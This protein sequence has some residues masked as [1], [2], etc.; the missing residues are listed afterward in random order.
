MQK[1][2]GRYRWTIAALLFFATTVN[3]VDRQVLSFVMTDDFFKKEM[4][5][6]PAGTVLTDDQ[7]AD[8]LKHMSVVDAVFK[9]TYA[10][11]FLIFGS[12]IDKIGTKKGYSSG[13]IMWSLAGIG[14][15]FVG[16]IS[17][18]RFTRG[19]LGL[20]ESANFPSAIKTVAEW[21]PKKERSFANG[22]FNAGSNLGVIATAL[23]VPFIIA[24]YGW[25][26]AF[27]VTGVLGFLILVAWLIFYDKPKESK[28]VSEEELAYICQDEAEAKPPV[29]RMPIWKVMR[30][31]QAWVFATGKFFGDPIWYFYLTWLPTFFNNN[32]V[33][34]QKLDLKNF[35]LS[36]F[37]I[38]AISDLGSVFFGWLSTRFMMRG[39]SEN[40]A[41]K[42]TLLIC[43]LCVVPI[44]FASTTNSL[45]VAIGLIS[46]ATAA[47]QGWSANVYAV[48]SNLFPSHMVASVT[49]FGGT[50]GSIG[51]VILGAST[52]YIVA[53]LG[54]S[55]MFVIASI[56]YLVGLGI[57]QLLMPTLKPI[58]A[59]P[60]D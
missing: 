14:N 8:F 31:R 54:Y 11:G 28:R 19:L 43:A 34:D 48:A 29:K 40:R 24:H 36:F 4:L 58:E 15:A 6:I 2:R 25:R 42:A 60:A 9:F 13:I 16:G 49:G 23:A 41:R 12:L 33:L 47:H 37:I 18:L 32:D 56:S 27:I 50:A 44:Y 57:I 5:G 38:Y 26:T 59:E 1:P 22:I 53:A 55:P 39:W 21:F 45:Y 30:Y 35:G 10:V 3:Y 17:G 51:G 46:L 7:N 20:G 52:G